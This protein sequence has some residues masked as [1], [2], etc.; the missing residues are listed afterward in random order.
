MSVEN[1]YVWRDNPPPRNAVVYGSYSAPFEWRLFMTCRSGC[2][3]R[4]I[5]DSSG[6][7]VLPRYWKPAKEADK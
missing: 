6:P 7:L 2:C 1:Y 3:V 4:E 5:P